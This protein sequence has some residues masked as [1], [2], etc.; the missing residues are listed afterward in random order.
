MAQLKDF[1]DSL[2][3]VGSR[4]ETYSVDL[5]RQLGPDGQQVAGGALL[6]RARLR[7]CSPPSTTAIRWCGC[8]R[9]KGWWPASASK[10]C[11]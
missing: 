3:R 7:D 6:E 9:S 11:G 1:L 8:G 5:F 2:E 4:D 10:R